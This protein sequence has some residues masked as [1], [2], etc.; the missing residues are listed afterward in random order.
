MA[1][2]VIPFPGSYTPESLTLGGPEETWEEALEDVVVLQCPEEG[3][4]STRFFLEL[5]ETQRV[6]CATC[7]IV[8]NYLLSAHKWQE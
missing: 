1:D 2:N 8:S 5:E 4:E 7:L 6:I 3:C